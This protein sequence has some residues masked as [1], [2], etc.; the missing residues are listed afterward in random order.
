M[1]VS[2]VTPA[3]PF[4]LGYSQTTHQPNDHTAE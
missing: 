3:H 2:I 4:A 1:M